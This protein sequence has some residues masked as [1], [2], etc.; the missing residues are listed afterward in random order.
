MVTRSFVQ[1]LDN[2]IKLTGCWMAKHDL[3]A[4]LYY[5]Q[6]WNVLFL[7]SRPDWRVVVDSWY[8]IGA[9][10]GVVLRVFEGLL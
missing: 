7:I 5:P 4:D 1:I 10:G 3:T 8:L 9:I 6:S 2:K